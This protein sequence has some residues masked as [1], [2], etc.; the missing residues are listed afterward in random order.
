MKPPRTIRIFGKT[1]AMEYGPMKKLY[2]RCFHKE[3]RIRICNDKPLDQQQDTSIH[4]VLH[5]IDLE[6]NLEL[7]EKKIR[8]L[9]TCFLAILKDNPQYTKFL[10]SK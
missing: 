3:L 7:S 10:L 9:A 5:A 4:E 2:G 1:W 8:R 6:L